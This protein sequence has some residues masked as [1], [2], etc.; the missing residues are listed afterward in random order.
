MPHANHHTPFPVQSR[1][2]CEIANVSL[3]LLKQVL[4]AYRSYILQ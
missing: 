3:V 2:Q 1:L 4:G